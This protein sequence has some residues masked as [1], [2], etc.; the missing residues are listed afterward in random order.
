M[1][2]DR[3]DMLQSPTLTVGEK[4]VL[5]WILVSSIS[6]K[7]NEISFVVQRKLRT[8]PVMPTELIR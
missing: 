2:S 4:K 5:N 3:P 8:V 6:L 1:Q 7:N